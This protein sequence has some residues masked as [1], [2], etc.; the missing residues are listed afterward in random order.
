[1]EISP[2]DLDI[3][4]P[5]VKSG[6]VVVLQE[7]SQ[8]FRIISLMGA[9]VQPLSLLVKVCRTDQSAG[10]LHHSEALLQAAEMLDLYTMKSI[11]RK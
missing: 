5:H 9:A 2:S 8:V 7:R 3:F 10:Q 1:M 11:I 4:N 6:S